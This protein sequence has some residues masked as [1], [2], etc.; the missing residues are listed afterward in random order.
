MYSFKYYLFLVG[1][2][3]EI[4]KRRALHRVYR[5]EIFRRFKTIYTMS[6]PKTILPRSIYVDCYFGQQIL[7]HRY[8]MNDTLTDE[9]SFK[10]FLNCFRGYN[11]ELSHNINQQSC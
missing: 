11:T 5:S 7:R 1:G 6:E 3:T 10:I 9:L 8:K 2:D 4:Y